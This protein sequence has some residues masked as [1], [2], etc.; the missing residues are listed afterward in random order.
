MSGADRKN[1]AT[2]DRTRSPRQD[3]C[4]DYA[5]G[6]GEGAAKAQGSQQCEIQS[7]ACE[8]THLGEVE[9]KSTTL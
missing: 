2:Q 3:H 1:P 9:D 6:F 8:R 5:D 4:S 7:L